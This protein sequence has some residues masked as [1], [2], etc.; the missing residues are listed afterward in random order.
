VVCSR[1]AG[2]HRGSDARRDSGSDLARWRRARRPHARRQRVLCRELHA[3]H[4]IRGEAIAVRLSA[5]GHHGWRM[6]Q[7][8]RH[9]LRCVRGC[10]T[11]WNEPYPPEHA[12]FCNR[13][14]KPRG[15]PRP[16]AA[17]D[18]AIRVACVHKEVRV[19]E[20]EVAAPPKEDLLVALGIDEFPPLLLHGKKKK[21][22]HRRKRLADTRTTRSSLADE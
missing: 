7:R 12:V 2:E 21:Q 19:L 17:F 9:R 15:R 5:R 8:R 14:K 13:H 10:S 11:A 16:I 18:D 22:P 3:P 4:S 20:L 1:L 6:A